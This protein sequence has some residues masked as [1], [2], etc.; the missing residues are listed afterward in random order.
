MECFGKRHYF[1]CLCDCGIEKEVR[2]DGLTSVTSRSCGCGWTEA[3]RL[4]DR[5]KQVPHKRPGY[6]DHPLYSIWSAMHQRCSNPRLKCYY[7][8]GGRGIT[9]CERWSEFK[10]FLADMGLPPL[11]HSID[12]IDNDGNYAPE[13]CRWAPIKQQANNTRANFRITY[14]GATKTLAE[15]SDCTG[16]N[17]NTLHNRLRRGQ[18]SVE[19]AFTTPPL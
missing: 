6:K 17:S 4:V 9:V 2:S 10:N 18:W 1:R 13:N 7:N 14:G 12:R 8:Y 15:W 11:K 5:S 3:M 16:I 19:R